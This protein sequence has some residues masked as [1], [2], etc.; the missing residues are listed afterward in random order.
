[1]TTKEQNENML[2]IIEDEEPTV[3]EL[4]RDISQNMYLSRTNETFK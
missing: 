2:K 3:D 1:M 4:I